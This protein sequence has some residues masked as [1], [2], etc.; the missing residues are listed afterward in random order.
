MKTL[1]FLTCLLF[2]LPALAHAQAPRVGVYALK[3]KN[4]GGT[5]HYDGKVIIQ[6]EGENYRLTWLIGTQQAQSGVAILEEDVLSVGYIDM[7]GMD[8]GVVSFKII[9]AEKITGKWASIYSKGEFG[10]EELSFESEQIPK[11][12]LP[13]IREKKISI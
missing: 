13:K 3:G 10:I 7:S 12:F 4:A 8:F 2:A 5:K 9:S 11:G 1:L 6:K